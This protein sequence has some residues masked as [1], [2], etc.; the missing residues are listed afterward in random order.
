MRRQRKRS[1]TGVQAYF[2]SQRN[3]E[4]GGRT[5]CCLEDEA[6]RVMG[7]LSGTIDLLWSQRREIPRRWDLIP[8]KRDGVLFQQVRAQNDDNR[9]HVDVALQDLEHVAKAYIG[10]LE[11]DEGCVGHEMI[12]GIIEIAMFHL[13]HLL[14]EGVFQA[15][16]G[17]GGRSV[18]ALRI[19]TSLNG[20]KR[21]L[22][23]RDEDNNKGKCG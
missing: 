8:G 17:E 21:V 10:W 12:E 22:S 3:Q 7:L 2:Q 4:I 15:L 11:N 13:E 16:G 6:M 20:V 1:R 23:I 19:L 9:Q 18:A 5:V 14:E